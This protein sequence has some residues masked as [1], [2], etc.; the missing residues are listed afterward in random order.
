MNNLNPSSLS[1]SGIFEG[2]TET[3]ASDNYYKRLQSFPTLLPALA[4]DSKV[5]ASFYLPLGKDYIAWWT[6]QTNST[7]KAQKQRQP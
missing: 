4:P 1:N 5:V 3:F 7:A 2:T 6:Q